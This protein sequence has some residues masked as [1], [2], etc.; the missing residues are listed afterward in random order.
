QDLQVSGSA[1]WGGRAARG[2]FAPVLIDLDNR[3]KKDADLSITV[4]WAASSATQ[5]QE[6]PSFQ[7]LSGRV[8]PAHFVNLTLHPQSRKRLSL[9][10]LTPDSAQISVWVF[11]LDE[12]GRS[13]ARAELAIRLLDPHQRL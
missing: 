11:A 7:N 2:E 3:G 10:V 8:G 13:V 4:L 12:K 5:P 1:G 9:S 6:N